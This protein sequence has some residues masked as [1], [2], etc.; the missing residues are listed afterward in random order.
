M[1]K[2]LLITLLALV[3]ITTIMDSC[4]RKKFDTPPY[5]G[6]IDPNINVNKTILDLKNWYS[7]PKKIDSAWVISGVV[8]SSDKEGS[9]YKELIIQDSSS[10]IS[11]KLDKQGLYNEYPV[12]R[13]IFVKLKGMQISDYDGFIQIGYDIDG[14]G[15]LVDVPSKFIPDFV[16]K[17]KTGQNIV[18][19]KINSIIDLN[20][21][22]ANQTKIGTLIELDGIQMP[23]ASLGRTYADPTSVNSGTNLLVEECSQASV[24]IR[25]SGF[26]KFQAY[27]V[28]KGKGK[29]TAIVSTFGGTVQLLVRDTTDFKFYGQ[30]C[31][32]GTENDTLTTI[33]DLRNSWLGTPYTINNRK[34]RGIVISNGDNIASNRNLI[35]QDRASGRGLTFRF[36]SGVDI[37]QDAGITDGD[38]VEI[39]L[40][41][42]SMTEFAGTLQLDLLKLSKIQKVAAT[43]KIVPKIVSVQDA[44][45][46]WENLESTLVTINNLTKVNNTPGEK[47][48]SGPFTAGNG[49]VISLT[50]DANTNSIDNYV[51]QYAIPS[52]KDFICPVTISSLTGILIQNKITAGDFKRINIRRLEDVKQ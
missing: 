41:G 1:K 24:I 28:Q 27:P 36:E 31:P 42:A 20:A 6:D 35:V 10:G 38:S 40:N 46:D 4:V 48:Y 25:T 43:T 22:G 14:A 19:E 29:L 9:F 15:R 52:I 7:G 30:R 39:L 45:Q 11:L 2:N 5:E 37:Y 51:G 47:F 8:I 17:G 16:L 13:R 3:S 44:L 33:Q 34:V 26:S 50:D 49:G 32:F 21:F 12:G 18:P 23:G